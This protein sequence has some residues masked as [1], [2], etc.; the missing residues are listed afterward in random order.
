MSGSQFKRREEDANRQQTVRAAER[1]GLGSDRATQPLIAVPK[2][3]TASGS[4]QLIVVSS[5]E[6]VICASSYAQ[7]NSHARRLCSLQ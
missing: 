7:T 6:S 1:R 5:S 2:V 3:C 4:N